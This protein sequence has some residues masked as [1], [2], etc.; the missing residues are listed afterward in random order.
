L[1][2]LVKILQAVSGISG[3]VEY[4]EERPGE[5]KHSRADID[6]A[7]HLLGFKPETTLE[8]GFKQTWETVK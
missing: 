2:K 7:G 4:A 5:I 6:K 1:N 8:L 3:K